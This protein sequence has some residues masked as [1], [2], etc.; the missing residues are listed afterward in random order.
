MVPHRNSL[1]LGKV[2]SNYSQLF[3]TVINTKKCILYHNLLHI[4]PHTILPASVSIKDHSWSLLCIDQPS[5]S[6]SLGATSRQRESNRRSQTCNFSSQLFC[7][8][9]HQ[10]TRR[11]GS[12]KSW[13]FLAN[14]TNNY[15][16]LFLNTPCKMLQ[17]KIVGVLETF[18]HYMCLKIPFIPMWLT[19]TLSIV[20]F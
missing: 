10:N 11:I 7:Q 16:R 2:H 9:S 6:V 14:H 12:R 3:F 18:V 1:P 13:K 20:S 8:N 15:N 4:Y 17:N 5:F 19:F